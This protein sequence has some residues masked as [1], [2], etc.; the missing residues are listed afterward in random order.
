MPWTSEQKV[1]ALLRLPWTLSVEKDSS[2]DL[3]AYVRE[4]PGVVATGSSMKALGIDLWQS[5]KAT[6]ECFLE[7]NDDIPLPPGASLPWV[8]QAAPTEPRVNRGSL[9]GDGWSPAVVSTTASSSMRV[10]IPA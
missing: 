3:V 1:E 2:G 8:G 9:Q 6:L 7:F 4:I 10:A 5:L